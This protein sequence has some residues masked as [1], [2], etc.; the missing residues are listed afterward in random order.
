MTRSELARSRHEVV[1]RCGG[2]CEARTSLACSSRAQHIHHLRFRSQGGS[3]AASNLI[4]VCLVCHD[5]IHTHPAEAAERG[6]I[7]RAGA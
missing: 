3:D 4:A 1:Q 2:L 7:V 5:W 6:L